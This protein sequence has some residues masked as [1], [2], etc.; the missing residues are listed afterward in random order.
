MS[1]KNLVNKALVLLD[2]GEGERAEAV[3]EDAIRA[4]ETEGDDVSLGTALCVLGDWLI[5]RGARSKG[6]PYLRRLLAI[7]REDD[8]LDR[9]YARARELLGEPHS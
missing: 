3:L 9:E 8:V 5:Q 2:R 4:G 1:A 7:A 6:E